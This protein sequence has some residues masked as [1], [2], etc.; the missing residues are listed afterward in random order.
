[1]KPQSIIIVLLVLFTGCVQH[2]NDPVEENEFRINLEE[3][4]AYLN[5]LE[6][7]KKK[8]GNFYFQRSKVYYELKQLENARAD[9]E[10]AIK[11]DPS[12]SDYFLLKG[13]IEKADNNPEKAI[14][15]LLIAEK[16]GARDKDLYE[17]LASEYLHINQPQ[18]AKAAVNR[19]IRVKSNASSY[20]LKG[21][22]LLAVADTASAIINY[23]KAIDVGNVGTEPFLQLSD[24]YRKKGKL[25]KSLT[26]L[27]SFSAEDN[28]VAL[29]K[30]RL[31]VELELYDSAK[32]IYKDL[33][34]QDSSISYL[35]FELS[36]IYY[37]Q[38]NYDSASLYADKA[39]K[40]NTEKLEALLVSARSLDNLRKYDSAISV[41][42]F[43]LS[44]DS[45]LEV[46]SNELDIL[47][48]K[49]AYLWRLERLKQQKDSA[50]N[51]LPP[52][53]EKKNIEN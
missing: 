32:I 51:N 22:V 15:N 53:I 10:K 29:Q 42:E 47:K 18:K 40:L 19:L 12:S 21:D 3:T 52:T 48:R 17:I 7:E 43:I 30:G 27:N 33:I 37:A 13:R 39:Y 26:Y 16:L 45:T 50:R 49:V 41:Y 46:A 25:E 23:E 8:G 2:S 11:N 44:R 5:E 38:T 36:S 20:V 1:M 4:L 14:E 6:P 34:S 9:I 35:H 28:A 31:L 24:I